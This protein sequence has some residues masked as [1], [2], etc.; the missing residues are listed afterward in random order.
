M[1]FSAD[2]LLCILRSLPQPQNL[3]LA[4]SGGR[5]S[6]V[7]L[8]AL[9]QLR[10]QIDAQLRVVHCDH[11]LHADSAAWSRHCEKLCA[12]IG[13][14]FTGLRLDL[15]RRPGR[16]LEALARAARYRAIAE[17]MGPGDLL[18]TA[19]HR[20]DQAETVLLQL[21]RGSGIG[22]LAAMAGLTRFPP[23]WLARPLLEFSAG[24]LAAYAHE[25][26]LAWIEDPSNRD[27]G[28]DRNYLRNRVIPL[29]E[30]RWPAMGRTLSRSARHCAEAHALIEEN[31]AADLAHIGGAEP[32]ILPVSGLLKLTAARRRAVLRLWIRQNGFPVPDSN[33]LERVLDEV[34]PAA[35]DR[36]PLLCW[37]GAE[38]RRHRDS[39]HLLSPLQSHD[40][41][42]LIDW[43]RPDPLLQLPAGLGAL[44]VAPVVGAGIDARAWSGSRVQVGFRRGGERCHPAG[45]RR[46]ATLKRLLQERGVPP[47]L[48]DRVPLLY[49]NG[50][51]AAVADLWICKPFAA[52][53]EGTGVRLD[54]QRSTEGGI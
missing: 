3:W 51:L 2:R 4:F 18:L 20:N 22:G 40:P 7:L 29:L 6:H 36:S 26:G 21:L 31:A 54:W 52:A 53:S 12:T 23:G 11:G 14:R 32:R 46:G 1:G 41:T 42:V 27:L 49:L 15:A 25:A 48:R 24:A 17:C 9:A 34:L 37:D 8:H 44:R 50:E 28:F 13:V 38:L 10:S 35:W 5:D 45:G 43:R 16:S 19:H 33:R 39:L 30:A 47:W